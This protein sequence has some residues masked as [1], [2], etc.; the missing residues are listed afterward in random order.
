LPPSS[1][2]TSSDPGAPSTGTIPAG[3]AGVGDRFVIASD[4]LRLPAIA[5][6]VGGPGTGGGAHARRFVEYA[7][8]QQIDIRRL[9][10]ELDRDGR[11][12]RSVLIVPNPG[13]TAVLFAGPAGAPSAAADLGRLIDHA[14]R[15]EDAARIHLAQALVEPEDATLG[16]A[17]LAGGF[18]RLAELAYLE[19]PVPPRPLP[20]PD[21]PG[22]VRVVPWTDDRRED[23]V[24]VLV[25]SYEDTLDCPGLRGL[26]DPD[27]ILEGHVRAGVFEPG[28]W[29]ILEI[30]GVAAGVAM[31]NASPGSAS[32]ELVY[33]GLAAAA[34]GRGLGRRLLVEALNGIAGRPEH[35]VTLAVDLR[36]EPALGLYRSLG[37][38]QRMRRI[39]YVRSLR[40]AAGE[41]ATS[42]AS[43]VAAPH[44]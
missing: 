3:A 14:C 42:D 25:S 35:T 9:W 39:A 29:R 16:A 28:L 20:P 44:A 36:N 33:L 21:W 5:R 17:F 12:I 31:L 18:G 27:D 2:P 10:T 37:F 40:P 23:V 30:D 11:P 15:H 13:R 1:T 6:L 8:R 7:T 22:D 38:H 41:A 32:I 34:R 24:R 4:A 26:R 19:R 43:P